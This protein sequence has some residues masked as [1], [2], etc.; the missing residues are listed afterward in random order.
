[1]T[2]SS[3][4]ATGSPGLPSRPNS[5][6]SI[7]IPNYN[8]AAWLP[9]CLEGL[10]GQA[11]RDFEI[12]LVDNGSTD[13]SVALVRDRYPDVHVIVLEHNTGFAAAVNRGIAS[14]R[15]EYVAL[16]NNDTVAKPGWLVALVELADASPIEVGAIASKM[17]RM[18]EMP[19][20]EVHMVD[21]G[22]APGGV[23]EPGVPPI[24]PAICAG[25]AKATGKRVRELPLSRHDLSW[26]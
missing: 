17:L 2:A 8:G 23:G 22:E 18:D 20:V 9:G 5:N 21:S 12:I 15:G 13:D 6:V 24:A 25:I 19:D 26:G 3:P 14:A 16:L 4:N 1:M 7:V 11:Y 10:A